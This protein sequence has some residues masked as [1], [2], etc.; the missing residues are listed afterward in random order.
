MNMTDLEPNVLFCQGSWRIMN[1]ILKTL[2]VPS[3][4]SL[5]S[6]ATAGTHLQ[7]LAKLLLLLV[8]YAE[9]KVYL[10]CLLESWFHA[11]YLRECL[12]RMLQRSIAI[13]ENPNAVPKFGFLSWLK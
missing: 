12:F 8:Y 7:A 2:F 13:V 3:Q 11:H 1:D 9:P 6:S 10:V 5:D 4:S